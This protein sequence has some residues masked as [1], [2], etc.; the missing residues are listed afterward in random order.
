LKLL[1]DENLSPR[2][3]RWACE[4]GVP[5][6]AVVHLGLAGA[7]DAAVFATAF[8]QDQVVVTHKDAAAPSVAEA[9]AAREVFA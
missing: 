1:I 9:V 2:L 4:S 7:S 6:E 3:A 8:S 5:A